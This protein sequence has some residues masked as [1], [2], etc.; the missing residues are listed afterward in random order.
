MENSNPKRHNV[1]AYLISG[2]VF[3][4]LT[5]LCVLFLKPFAEEDPVEALRKTIDA[6]TIP[7]VFFIGIGIISWVSALGGYDMLGFAVS[8][9][10]LHNILPGVGAKEDKK[11][12]Y[13]YKQEKE[14]KGRT[15]LKEMFVVGLAGLIL[16]LILLALYC[17]KTN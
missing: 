7:T 4:A 14:E 9:F 2:A 12:Y 11:S 16:C 15:W 10:S 3:V 6:F 1:K 8:R 17:G 13:E 5:I